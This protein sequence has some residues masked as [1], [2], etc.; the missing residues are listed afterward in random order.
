MVEGSNH[1]TT[2]RSVEQDFEDF[3]DMF[4]E[5]PG[6]KKY[7]KRIE[8]IHARGLNTLYVKY[9][10]IAVHNAWLA[11][12][13]RFEPEDTL[14]TLE[15]V[16][17]NK[18]K[19]RFE[20]DYERYYIR[21]TIAE[22]SI[23]TEPI[24]DL[25]SKDLN[26]LV[27]FVGI[28][29]R[30]SKV[31]PRLTKA[32]FLCN[33]CGSGP[34]VKDVS[35]EEI[36]N[37]VH[38]PNFCSKKKCKAKSSDFHFLKNDSE[39]ID[40]QYLTVQ[41]LPETLDQGRT[42]RSLTAVLTEDLVE[43][44]QPGERVSI[45]GIYQ[46]IGKRTGNKISSLFET[47]VFVNN[48]TSDT[49]EDIEQ[50]TKEELKKIELL[51]KDENIQERIANSVAFHICGRE[52]LKMI[53]ALA[54]FGGNRRKLANGKFIRGDIHALFVGDPGTGKS[55]IIK[56]AVSISPRGIYT[57]GQG[58]SEV[59]LTAA[60]VRDEFTGQW[61]LEAGAI[62]L[63]NGGIL[64]IDELEK[65]KSGVAGALNEPMEHQTVSV[66]KAGIVATLLSRT[67]VL[68]AAN[69]H[70]GRYDTNKSAPQNIRMDPSLLSRFDLIFLVLDNSDEN[71]DA[72]II[73]HILSNSSLNDNENNGNKT[74]DPID[75]TLLRKYISI[76]KSFAPVLT[77]GAKSRI[78]EFYLD[79][80]KN[81]NHEEAIV[82]IIPRNANSLIR[83]SE[84]HAKMALRKKVLE[85]DV[86]AIIP[87]FRRYIEDTGLDPSTGKIDMT[88][89][90]AGDSQKNL[91]KLD[92]FHNK[93]KDIFAENNYM[94]LDKK[95]LIQ[96]IEVEDEFD[97]AYV[98]RAVKEYIKEGT[99]YEP[100]VGQIKLA[101]RV[102]DSS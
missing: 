75:R 55:E 100:K 82:Q 47:N 31:K 73:D 77:K 67:S 88:R 58:A 16:L 26:H 66:A 70:Y 35:F 51:S 83:L 42:P 33:L 7:R 57:S 86:D 50:I 61:S 6:I 56:D 29:V 32:H 79:L 91:N 97:R 46:P 36:A 92:I 72:Q 8:E 74:L 93:L 102:D 34:I 44:A 69:P 78:K 23:L 81:T 43:T 87:L 18:I 99:L 48:L 49:K 38:F 13:L 52:D 65:L 95:G 96:V 9:E 94:P 30:S 45:I 39:Y 37:G 5:V 80:R 59:G 22:K 60:T 64:A 20:A 54:L 76:A 19:D 28:I 15:E 89:L 53:C 84:A 3:L 10:D 1:A 17:L 85:E 68:S 14:E 40:Y 27:E 4:E 11:V 90:F 62:V 21:I 12:K 24:I 101:S 25:R 71:F 63:A 41:E 98:E 2:P